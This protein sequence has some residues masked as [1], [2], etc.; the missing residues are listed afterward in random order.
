[1]IGDAIRELRE[2][3]AREKARLADILD[4]TADR[5]E[6]LS[7]STDQAALKHRLEALH[8]AT[9]WHER[10]EVAVLRLRLDFLAKP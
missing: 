1:M 7:R 3:H 2:E 9:A 6:R 5:I 10:I 8:V 4:A